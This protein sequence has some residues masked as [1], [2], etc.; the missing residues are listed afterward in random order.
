MSETKISVREAESGELVVE[1]RRGPLSDEQ[2][3][4]VVEPPFTISVNPTVSTPDDSNKCGAIEVRA[5]A[6]VSVEEQ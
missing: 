2:L 6:D 1:T 3:L 4:D 5:D